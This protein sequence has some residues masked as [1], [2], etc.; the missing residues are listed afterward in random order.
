M[1][2]RAIKFLYAIDCYLLYLLSGV[3]ASAGVV[4]Y[5]SITAARDYDISDSAEFVDYI[6]SFVSGKASVALLVSY[7]IVVFVMLI[8]FAILRKRLS[9]YTGLSYARPLSVIGA[10]L[11]GGVLNLIVY[12]VTPQS[13]SADEEM[14]TL[15]FLCVMI[16]PVV[17]ELMFRGVLLKMFGSACGLFAASLITSGLFALSHSGSVQVIYTFVL[18]VILCSV[19][20]SSTSLWSAIALHIS[21]NLAGALFM[22]VS[23][24]ISDKGLVLLV[25]A[26]I[27]CFVVACGGGRKI[28][29]ES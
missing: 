21:F 1:K 5:Y 25:V 12:Q 22:V 18:G 23:P 7:L 10:F 15:L 9:A 20:I 4:I 2:E 14:S 27:L 26:A 6:S 16:G 24:S 8:T 28:A 11:L 29:K 19:R 17:E 3:V 13:I